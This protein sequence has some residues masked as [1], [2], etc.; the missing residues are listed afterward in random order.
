MP[1]SLKE[2]KSFLWKLSDDVSADR[3]DLVAG[4][5]AFYAMLA[6]F[7]MLVAAI[8]IYGLFTT[9]SGLE[10]QIE[11]ISEMMPPS[12]HAIVVDQLR[13]IDESSS[14]GL[15]LGVLFGLGVALVSASRGTNALISSV[16]IAYDEPETRSFL[17]MRLLSL[18]LTLVLIVGVSLAFAL[19]AIVPVALSFVGLKAYGRLA[20][21]IVRWCTLVL[22]FMSGLS[23]IYRSAPSTRA[24]RYRW[25]SPGSIVAT[26]LWVAASYGFSFYVTRFGNYQATY[27][28]VGGAVV[29]LLW[30]WISAYAILL[31]AEIDAEVAHHPP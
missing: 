29:L 22:L 19:V 24:R 20:A 6:L 16:G 9:P 11:K 30:L 21:E 4:G 18:G 5:V 13:S 28:S 7:P 17:R 15:T 26:L 3:I 25:V 8:S 31:G 27:G 2:L 14:E 23:V 1:R 10:R 12:A